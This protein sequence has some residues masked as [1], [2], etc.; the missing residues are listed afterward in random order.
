MGKKGSWFVA[1]K[2]AFSPESKEKKH[3]KSGKSKHRWICRTSNLSSDSSPPPEEAVTAVTGD[4][5]FTETTA[6]PTEEA[7]S[8]ETITALTGET[9]VPETVTISTERKTIDGTVAIARE[10]P[11]A[12]ETVRVPT[13]E[14]K[15]EEDVRV[16]LGETKIAETPRVPTEEMKFSEAENSH[17]YSVAVATAIA[18]E[19]AV[20]AAQAAAEVVRLTTA[21]VP[22]FSGKCREDTA[23]IKIQTAFR[24]YLARRALRALRGLVRLKA[25]I[26][27]N[28]VKRQATATLRCMQTLSRVQSQIRSRRLRMS[29]E[30]QALQRQLLLKR[31]R[32]L[33]NLKASM[34]EDWD[35]SPQSKEQAE[36][37]LITKQEAAIRRER[38]LAYAFTHQQQWRNSSKSSI[39]MFLDPNNPHWGWSW[40]ERWMAERPWENRSVTERDHSDSTSIRTATRS[41]G[42]ITKSYARRETSSERP[43]PV[44]VKP[45]R[46]S[47][48]PSTPQSK[49]APVTGKTRLTSPRSGCGLEEESRSMFSMQ[50]ER[51]RRHS[52]GGSSNG[53]DESLAS[54]PSVP[55]YMQPT[56]SA[57][58]KV[59]LSSPLGD[60]QETV[61]RTPFTMAKKR[62]SFPIAD[63]VHSTT[64]SVSGRRF[65]GPPK[66]EASQKLSDVH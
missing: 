66:V 21:S 45:A 60:K 11:K 4:A 9:K 12:A 63:K 15:L 39:P 51:S 43:S 14:A 32:E 52:I 29:E 42:E 2:K 27:G 58:A 46:P 19:A 36:A 18:A 30:N 7:K 34:G 53:D 25:L 35:D 8:A 48:G 55:S 47:S 49:P 41:A 62:L 65:S 44:A 16:S 23:A 17:A 20:A 59:R 38:A 24:G 40:L 37:K 56:K 3:G 61:E 6:V 22:R 54:S 10:E 50:S 33:E 1:V 5:K 13:E 64:S 57:R 28:S 26:E 31:Q